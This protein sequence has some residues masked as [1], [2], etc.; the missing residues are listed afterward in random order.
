MPFLDSKTIRP[1]YDVH[2]GGK[3]KAFLCMYVPAFI[4]V[5]HCLKPIKVSPCDAVTKTYKGMVDHLK[6]KHGI[7]LQEEITFEEIRAT[8]EP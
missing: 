4:E 2:D 7:K 6:F 5:T 1:L 8:T 3:P